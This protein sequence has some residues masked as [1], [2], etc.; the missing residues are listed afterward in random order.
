MLPLRL[1]W[2]APIP[3]ARPRVQNGR[4]ER[5]PQKEKEGHHGLRR[6]LDTPLRQTLRGWDR[7]QFSMTAAPTL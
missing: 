2:G 4:H 6:Y 1:R 7:A 5:I 3:T